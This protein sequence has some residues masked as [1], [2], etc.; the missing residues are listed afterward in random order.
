M[1]TLET[2]VEVTLGC[3]AQADRVVG[4]LSAELRREGGTASDED[5]ILLADV[6]AILRGHV[7]HLGELLS[8]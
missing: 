6:E 2:D 4:L 5:E 3:I 1:T 7:R 8:H